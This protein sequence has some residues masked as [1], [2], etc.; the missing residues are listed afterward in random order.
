MEITVDKPKMK[1]KKKFNGTVLSLLKSL[2]LS[3]ETVIVVRNGE[4]VNEDEV[5]ENKDKIKIMSV[6]SGG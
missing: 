1:L 2:E 6:V 3:K 5:L 4:L